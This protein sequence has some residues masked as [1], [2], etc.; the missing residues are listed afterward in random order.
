M[1]FRFHPQRSDKTLTLMVTNDVLSLNGKE[2][3]F[4]TVEEGDTLPATAIQSDW[5]AGPITRKKGMLEIT[6][7]LPLGPDAPTNQ[8]FPATLHQ[9]INGLVDLTKVERSFG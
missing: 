5:F 2:F 7:L 1:I 4:S 8:R 6:L 9:S 3:D